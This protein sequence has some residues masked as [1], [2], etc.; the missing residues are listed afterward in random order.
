[1]FTGSLP[2]DD[3]ELER[4]ESSVD[5]WIGEALDPHEAE[6]DRAR[7]QL[8]EAKWAVGPLLSLSAQRQR[9]QEV[10]AKIAIIIADVLREL[11]KREE[12]QRRLDKIKGKSDRM[13]PSAALGT[14]ERS[15][16]R[17]SDTSAM[18]APDGD[19]LDVLGRTEG[20]P[21][22]GGNDDALVSP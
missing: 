21:D 19:G 10:I 5:R 11:E 9:K 6:L 14:T 1:L 13:E 8:R 2:S 22:A 7:S 4:L 12:E 3:S 16:F 17:L 18:A 15:G 20:A